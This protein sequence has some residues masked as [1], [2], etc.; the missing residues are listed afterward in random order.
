MVATQNLYLLLS[1]MVIAGAK[2]VKFCSKV[3][4]KHNYK[5][6]MNVFFVC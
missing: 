5:F 1:L 4:D 6:Y 2:D 3:G